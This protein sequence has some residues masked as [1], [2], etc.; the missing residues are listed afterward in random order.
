M[1]KHP[2]F[3]H[4]PPQDRERLLRQAHL[5]TLEEGEILALEGDP[6]TAVYAVLRG[7]IHA[8]KTSAEGREQIVNSLLV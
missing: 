7:R 4:V 1:A 5:R 6:C 2:Y 8:L 3:R